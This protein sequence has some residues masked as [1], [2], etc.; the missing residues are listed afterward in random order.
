MHFF[1]ELLSLAL[2]L[3]VDKAACLAD[4][5]LKEALFCCHF[6]EA[7]QF[8]GSRFKGS[9]R[10]KG[11]D[12]EPEFSMLLSLCSIVDLSTD[13]QRERVWV[14]H[15]KKSICFALSG[16]LYLKLCNV[17]RVA[18]LALKDGWLK[19]VAHC[20]VAKLWS[21]LPKQISV[22]LVGAEGDKCRWRQI[23]FFVWSQVDW[24]EGQLS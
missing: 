2:F 8:I 17:K 18:E 10:S 7:A 13:I 23:A 16:W 1:K 9:V 19:L 21:F 22:P 11:V 24:V 20:Y 6:L 4:R 12:V 15:K 3:V 14:Q 5:E